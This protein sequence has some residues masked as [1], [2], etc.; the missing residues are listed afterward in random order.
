MAITVR[1]VLPD[2]DWVRALRSS[3]RVHIGAMSEEFLVRLV[4][5]VFKGGE[6][7]PGN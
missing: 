2:D 5:D 3:L 6:E 1:R 4:Q 7:E